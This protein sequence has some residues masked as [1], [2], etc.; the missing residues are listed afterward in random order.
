MIISLKHSIALFTVLVCYAING[1][2]N[3]DAALIEAANNCK[4]LCPWGHN[5]DSLKISPESTCPASDRSKYLQCMQEV[6][7]RNL[8]TGYME[9]VF[10]F[11][12][13][14]NFMVYFTG[15]DIF[16]IPVDYRREFRRL[17]ERL[18][19]AVV[20]FLLGNDLERIVDRMEGT[21][22]ETATRFNVIHELV[23]RVQGTVP[24]RLRR[25]LFMV[26][27]NS[28][29]LNHELDQLGGRLR[30]VETSLNIIDSHVSRL[31]SRD[32]DVSRRLRLNE[33]SQ[34]EA[35]Q[36]A[37]R[38][39]RELE[40][41]QQANNALS[42]RVGELEA[43]RQAN[44]ALSARVGELEAARQA[45][46]ARREVEP[47]QVASR[48]ERVSGGDEEEEGE[49]AAVIGPVQRSANVEDLIGIMST[50]I[51]VP[52]LS[53]CRVFGTV[54][55]MMERH[56]PSSRGVAIRESLQGLNWQ[57]SDILRIICPILDPVYRDDQDRH[58][59]IEIMTVVVM[60]D[61]V[62][63]PDNAVC[64]SC[65]MVIT[66]F[67][68]VIS[69]TRCGHFK[70]IACFCRDYWSDPFA[71][72]QHC[73]NSAGAFMAGRHSWNVVFAIYR[74][75]RG[76]M[77]VVRENM[78]RAGAAVEGPADAAEEMPDAAEDAPADAA[79]DA[80]DAAEDAPADAAEDVAREAEAVERSLPER[81]APS[82][83]DFCD[84]MQTF[85]VDPMPE[86]ARE[87]Q[88]V[89]E[90]MERNSFVARTN[91]IRETMH[92]LHWPETDILRIVCPYE[93][94]VYPDGFRGNRV[95]F[96][97]TIV[98]LRH[99]FAVPDDA[100][101]YSCGL[102][103][104]PHSNVISSTRCG[105]FKHFNCFCTEYLSDPFAA[106]PDCVVYTGLS[107][108]ARHDFNVVFAI[109]RSHLGLE[110]AVND[111]VGVE[112]GAQ[113]VLD[114][115][116]PGIDGLRRD[117]YGNL[118]YGNDNFATGERVYY[119]DESLTMQGSVVR[120]RVITHNDK[121]PV[122]GNCLHCSQDL[123]V[124]RQ[125]YVQRFRCA[126]M[127]HVGCMRGFE[128]EI[129][130]RQLCPQCRA[131]VLPR[132]AQF[133]NYPV[134][135]YER[136]TG[137]VPTEEQLGICVSCQDEM[138]PDQALVCPWLC[139]GEKHWVHEE[140]W[141]GLVK[142]FGLEDRNKCLACTAGLP[143]DQASR[144]CVP[145]LNVPFQDADDGM[146]A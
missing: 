116:I 56:A 37:Q 26:E 75:H 32:T 86:G 142:T 108:G 123:T 15:F 52:R 12:I 25:R 101:C 111:D 134:R 47:R 95:L 106:C 79:E 57:E 16:E 131:D 17:T 93:D 35:D 49:A 71:S 55:E 58:N 34:L 110:N 28:V 85:I 119:D 41:A 30:A 91:S 145:G 122:T 90:L 128:E 89:G 94:P 19:V 98:V 1:F 68:N 144:N 11:M 29:R 2:I 130:N 53:F 76:R 81:R 78:L 136:F 42:A 20:E 40:A 74:M 83:N 109:H 100:V 135:Q 84:M 39:R 92:R 24:P 132:K 33:A 96:S 27:D 120:Y 80:P 14:V 114:Y 140:C 129:V 117:N 141:D 103:I 5:L 61:R 97:M 121:K 67:S 66:P 46:R 21:R 7:G 23:D 10:L 99:S 9:F 70:H 113:Q 82:L 4:A 127:I 8:I 44:N 107:T 146:E 104:G 87:Y 137:E 126:H 45:D 72:C 88:T 124:Q 64:Y 77:H 13:W 43:A 6:Y 59:T 54:G 143:D 133:R 18:R 36:Q 115:D 105:H 48:R 50:F 118:L 63:V 3:R 38:A 139:G 102:G 22:D 65:G 69:S 125:T 73:V 112:A 51:V 31:N 60:H 62:A 138:K